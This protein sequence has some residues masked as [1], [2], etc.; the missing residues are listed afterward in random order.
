MQ[1]C[2]L[3]LP[4]RSTIQMRAKEAIV[5]F[6]FIG[7]T[8]PMITKRKYCFEWAPMFRFGYGK[9]VIVKESSMRRATTVHEGVDMKKGSTVSLEDGG[10]ECFPMFHTSSRKLVTR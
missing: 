7:L 8:K 4:S 5:A 6:S 2:R 10:A 3:D 9:S 1:D